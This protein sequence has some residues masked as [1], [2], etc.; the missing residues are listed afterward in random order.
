M[1]Y[2]VDL[3][4]LVKELCKLCFMVILSPLGLMAGVLFAW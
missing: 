2:I 3:I 4:Y 1:T